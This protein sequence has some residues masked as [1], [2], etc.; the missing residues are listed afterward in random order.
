MITDKI[1]ALAAAKAQVAQLEQSIALGLTRELAALPAAFG[2]SDV[3]AFVRAVKA[4]AGWKRGRPAKT[5]R[6]VKH[7]KR[8]KITD[9]IRAKV[10]KLV[11]AGKTGSQ[12]AKALKI[13]LPSVQNVKKALGLVRTSKKPARKPRA[14]RALAK[15]AAAPK[16][17]KKRVSPKK[18][19]APESK[20]GQVSDAVAPAP[21]A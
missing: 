19:A 6:L 14:R 12:I 7:R 18:S 9:A 1:K 2:F 20:P 16:L 5:P 21:S 13:S 8:A 3:G 15:S 11:E 4:A 17:R 10:K